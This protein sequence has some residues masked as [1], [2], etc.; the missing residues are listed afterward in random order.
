V[1]PKRIDVRNQEADR[2]GFARS[3]DVKHRAIEN[4]VVGTRTVIN[5][6]GV[7][8]G[9]VR[10]AVTEIRLRTYVPGSLEEARQAA[11]WLWGTGCRSRNNAGL[12]VHCLVR[13]LESEK[14]NQPDECAHMRWHISADINTK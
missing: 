11:R 2:R 6:D 10:N 5:C 3:A 4:E 7:I 12:S 8:L 1:K 9:V 13:H 14:E